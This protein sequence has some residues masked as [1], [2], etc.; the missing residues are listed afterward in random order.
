M[1]SFS[2]FLRKSCFKIND[3]AAWSS[4]DPTIEGFPN[5]KVDPRLMKQNI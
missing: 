2:Y 1:K 4:Q 5:H 3:Y